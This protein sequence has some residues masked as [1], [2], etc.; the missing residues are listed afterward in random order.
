[1][2]TTV[3]LPPALMRA[4]KMAAADRGISLKEL[5]IKALSQE[6]GQAGVPAGGR[7]RLPLVGS[8]SGPRV[9]ITYH[10]IEAAFDAEDAHRYGE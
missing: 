9:D 10:D 2:R 1:M 8:S 6:V 4:A 3:D 7:V 5:F